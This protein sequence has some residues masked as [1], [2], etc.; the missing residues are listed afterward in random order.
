MACL[1]AA[2]L[3]GGMGCSLESI[4]RSVTKRPSDHFPVTAALG[5]SPFWLAPVKNSTGKSLLL[6]STNPV[7]SVREMMGKGSAGERDSVME[8]LRASTSLEL[9]RRDIAVAEP[10][11]LDKRLSR[12]PGTVE[13][14]V[15]TARAAGMS[16]NVLVMD[17]KR[18]TPTKKF[19]SVLIEVK[20]IDIHAGAAVW[21]RTI[22]GAVPTPSAV[23]LRDGYVDAVKG[24]VKE[25]FPPA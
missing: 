7:D 10:E 6:P 22:L 3:A 25:L 11:S 20:L 2:L 5:S 4:E 17:I 18:W 8:L 14:A 9:S 23:S 15:Q 12:F 21:E 19:V 13:N 1:A 24:I 16:G